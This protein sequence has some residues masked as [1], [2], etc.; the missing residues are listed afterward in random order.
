M[1][2]RD[3]SIAS[4]SSHWS[5]LFVRSFLLACNLFQSNLVPFAFSFAHDYEGPSSLAISSA[6]SCLP[7]VKPFGTSVSTWP[8]EH[9]TP[10]PVVGAA[11]YTLSSRM[12]RRFLRG[13]PLWSQSPHFQSHH[14]HPC[15]LSFHF[16]LLPYRSLDWYTSRRECPTLPRRPAFKNLHSIRLRMSVSSPVLGPVSGQSRR[17]W[18]LPLRRASSANCLYAGG[19]CSRPCN[20][21]IQTIRDWKREWV[22][23]CWF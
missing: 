4:L 19:R 7:F 8:S 15:W 18:V 13:R 14:S 1:V 9:L 3:L 17:L 16:A 22:L 10:L 5:C 23:L 12:P 20:W 6:I 21:C 11:D 2:H